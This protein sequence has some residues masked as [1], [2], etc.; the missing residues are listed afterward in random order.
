MEK[1]MSEMETQCVLDCLDAA[2]L[3]P[4]VSECDRTQ[5]KG[6]ETEQKKSKSDYGKER[7]YIDVP[8]QSSRPG[9]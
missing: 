7:R 3:V 2:L 4:A 9:K 1:S 8:H 5:V 6:I